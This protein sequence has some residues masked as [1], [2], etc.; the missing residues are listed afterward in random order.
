MSNILKLSIFL[1]HSLSA[2]LR[3]QTVAKTVCTTKQKACAGWEGAR[4]Q[5]A[6]NEF[7]GFPTL[8]FGLGERR[9]LNNTKC[10]TVGFCSNA[11]ASPKGQAGRPYQ[12]FDGCS[13]LQST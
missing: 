4:S 5:G 1:K 10:I 7:P 2:T 8:F 9:L 6:I 13:W 12:R 11:P 3:Q